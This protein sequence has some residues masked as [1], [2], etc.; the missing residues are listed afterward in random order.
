MNVSLSRF[1]ASLAIAAATLGLSSMPSA[2]A[3]V[4]F[5]NLGAS[6]TAALSTT[7]T[8]ITSTFRIAVPFTTGSDSSFLKLQSITL[9]LFYD[10]L[11]TSSFGL[12]IYED[13][14]GVPSATVAATAPAQNVGTVGLYTF[15]FSSFQMASNTTYWIQPAVDLSWYTPNSSPT[16][17]AYN[18]SGYTWPGSGTASND[19]GSTWDTDELVVVNGRYAF[20]VQAVPEPSTLVLAAAA[21][22]L[23]CYA[24]ARR[25]RA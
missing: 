13:N 15:N 7:N 3:E 21:L 6:G 9:G 2:R 12:S 11:E 23:G 22:G 14:S 18:S 17:V 25:R 16:P 1:F 19:G 5:G 10:N 24:A 8:D 4:V 20:S